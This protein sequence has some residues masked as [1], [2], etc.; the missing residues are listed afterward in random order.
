MKKLFSLVVICLLTMVTYAQK[1]ITTSKDA[2]TTSKASGVYSFVLPSDIS[3]DQ[4]NSVKQYY[5][6]YFTVDFTESTHVMKVKL[7]A[8]D[9]MNYK[10]MNRLMVSLDI[11]KFFVDGTE[12][13]YDKMYTTY[14]K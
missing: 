1:S 3:A 10:V 5:V 12:M 13:D 6:S 9:E 2:L 7:L 8:K 4:V 14:M 11:R